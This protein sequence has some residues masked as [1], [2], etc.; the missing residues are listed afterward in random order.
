MRRALGDNAE[1]RACRFLQ[2]KGLTL[3][4][5]NFRSRI[6]EIDLIMRDKQDVVFV[7]VRSRA[8]NYYGSAIESIN[9]TKQKKILAT[10]L[11]F[12]QQRNWLDQ[13]N[14][15]FD[16]IGICQNQIEWIPN[17]FTADIL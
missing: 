3:I 17:A 10:A 11:F 8:Q 7:E 13:V 1:Q 5:Q 15:R 9:E 2:A 16:V 4:V 12:L 6:G 14:C